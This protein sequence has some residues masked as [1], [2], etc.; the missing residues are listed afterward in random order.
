[1]ARNPSR[2]SG[3]PMS[4]Q[5]QEHG[6]TG[7]RGSPVLRAIGPLGAR[8][9]VSSTSNSA[10]QLE[11]RTEGGGG[12]GGGGA[13]GTGRHAH[14]SVQDL[15]AM[16]NGARLH[17]ACMRLSCA[18]AKCQPRDAADAHPWCRSQRLACSCVSTLHRKRMRLSAQ[19]AVHYL[20]ACMLSAPTKAPPAGHHS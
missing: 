20:S 14:N 9:E 11:G 3:P 10:L 18:P 15:P 12:G 2:T 13:C 5:A 19:R 4:E 8:F 7:G 17:A 6:F 1:V 16:Q